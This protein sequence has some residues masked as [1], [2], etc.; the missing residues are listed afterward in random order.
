MSE[1]EIGGSFSSLERLGESRRDEIGL[2]FISS[3][4]FIL[5]ESVQSGAVAKNW[6]RQ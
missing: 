2:S 4:G 1:M 3:A 6:S 5:D